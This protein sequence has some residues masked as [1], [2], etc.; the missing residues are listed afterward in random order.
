MNSIDSPVS[1]D[2]QGDATPSLWRQTT[3]L[4]LGAGE[5]EAYSI[6][7]DQL[8]WSY[9]LATRDR[10]AGRLSCTQV[11]AEHFACARLQTRQV[12][13][14]AMAQ[15]KLYWSL[16]ND[17][18][19]RWGTPQRCGYP[20]ADLLYPMEQVHLLQLG[21]ELLLGVFARRT[22][23][24]GKIHPELAAEDGYQFWVGRWTG[25][26]FDFG[27]KPVSL[28]GDDSLGNAF[29]F[30]KPDVFSDSA[31]GASQSIRNKTLSAPQT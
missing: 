6:G 10:N 17:Q 31:T 2:F 23:V 21:F 11:P 26:G 28:R 1:P 3:V 18:P 15:Q 8:V 27:R 29:L 22:N 13:L 30:C 24:L 5:H 19:E 7:P 12:L 4:P 16:E 20:N 9:R 14:V 25:A